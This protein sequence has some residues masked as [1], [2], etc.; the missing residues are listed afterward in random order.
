MHAHV[1]IISEIS[2]IST[3][4]YTSY[5]YVSTQVNYHTAACLY[6]YI[7]CIC[8]HKKNAVLKIKEVYNFNC[9]VRTP[10]RNLQ[11]NNIIVMV[12]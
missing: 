5:L 6:V 8:A 4:L 10:K 7:M 2:D 11:V 12:E 3:T 9:N 1:C